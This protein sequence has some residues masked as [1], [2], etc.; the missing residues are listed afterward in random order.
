MFRLE[1]DRSLGEK[2][3]DALSSAAQTVK[4][5][6]TPEVKDRGHCRSRDGTP[7]TPPERGNG[8]P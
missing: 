4:D 7:G 6:F 8:S 5:A 2:A 1:D 3:M